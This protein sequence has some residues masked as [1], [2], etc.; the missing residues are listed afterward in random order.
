MATSSLRK[1]LSKASSKTFRRFFNTDLTQQQVKFK[2]ACRNFAETHLKPIAAELDRDCKFPTDQ[3]A[4]MSEMG[5][6][7]INVPKQWGG[8]G[9]DKLSTAL[10]VE[11]I[12]RCCGGT[13]AFVSI[14][15]FLY[16]NAISNYGTEEQKE[17][18][19]KPFLCNVGCFALSEPEAGSDAA[20][21]L[22]TARLEGDH[23]ILNGV[24][25]WV[26]SG[27]QGKAAI[28][29][30]TV[31]KH[32]KHKG[33]TAFLV[34][35]PIQNLSITKIEDKLGIRATSTCTFHLKDVKIPKKNV[36]GNVGEG[37]KIA[38]AQFDEARVGIASQAVGIS[39]AALELAVQYAGVRKCFG[40]SISKYQAVQ[41]RIADM[42][43]RLE[44]ARL[45][46]WNAAYLREKSKKST[47]ETSIAKLVAGEAATFITHNAIQILGGVGYIK[48]M[49]AERHY[50]DARVT[51]IYGGISDIHRLIIAQ[52]ILKDY[53]LH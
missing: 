30:A 38:M 48:D 24:K 17:E 47:R 43:A 11:E 28:I 12:S 51:E 23:Y 19:L 6:L 3:V 2:E 44:A 18:F 41:I 27:V 31:D 34:P 40:H 39:Q 37:F 22:T 25:S 45:L 1:L 9:L 16:M 4:G 29:F 7:G 26:T 33:I 14:H 5:L 15:N 32:L 8:L 46:V 49:S 13:G 52:S 53:K 42:A 21:I 20:N 36:L 50:R 10:A 35:L